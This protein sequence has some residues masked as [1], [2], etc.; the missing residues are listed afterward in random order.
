M[1]DYFT[2][3]RTRYHF[4]NISMKYQF[5]ERENARIKNNEKRM[6][7]E[8]ESEIRVRLTRPAPTIAIFKVASLVPFTSFIGYFS[9][10]F[11]FD[12]NRCTESS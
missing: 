4:K 2:D 10:T 7:I 1:F 9:M 6:K 11:H 12:W 3:G 5:D 8:I